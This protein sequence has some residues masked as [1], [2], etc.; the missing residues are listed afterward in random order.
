MIVRTEYLCC[1]QN[2]KKSWHPSTMRN[3]EKV[4]KAEQKHDQE[5]RRIA[6]LQR[7]IRE[8]IAREDI[9]KHAEDKGVVE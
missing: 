3:M 8:E 2:L 4:W 5:Q 6:E 1:L 7:E 9:Q